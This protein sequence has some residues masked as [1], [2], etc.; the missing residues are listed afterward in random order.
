M[1][2][3]LDIPEGLID[4]AMALTNAKTKSQLVKEALEAQI[5][6][7]KR[8]RLVVLKGTFDFDVDLDVLRGRND[9]KI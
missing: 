1:R 8:Q 7:I 5:K 9:V 4:E 3:T 6:R 2:T